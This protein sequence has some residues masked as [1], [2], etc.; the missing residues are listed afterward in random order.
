MVD[1]TVIITGN[2]KGPKLSK[3]KKIMKISTLQK[4]KK[5]KDCK[6]IYVLCSCIT[7]GRKRLYLS[8]FTIHLFSKQI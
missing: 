5:K 7:R 6:G 4:E 8:D 1:Y 3:G 2:Y